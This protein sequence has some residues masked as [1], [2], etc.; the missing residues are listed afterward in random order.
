MK[1]LKTLAFLLTALAFSQQ[2]SAEAYLQNISTRSLVGDGDKQQ[3]AGFVLSGSGNKSLLIKA[4]GQGL[5]EYGVDTLLNP[6]L[7]LIAPGTTSPIY[8]N[9]NWGDDA[10]HSEIPQAAQPSHAQDS[11]MLYQLGPGAYTAQV[12]PV[13]GSNQIGLVSVDD[14][15]SNDTLRLI[16]ISTRSL[17]GTGENQAIL[18][19]VIGGNEPLTVL[20]KAAGKSLQSYGVQTELDP[21]MQL[22]NMAD[23]SS[24]GTND[25]WQNYAANVGIPA[26]LRPTHNQ[27]AAMLISLEPG[28]Y[29]VLVASISNIEDIGLVSI[30]VI[31]GEI[32]TA[33]PALRAAQLND[34]GIT[35]SSA[36]TDSC[37]GDNSQL[38]DCASGRDASHNDDSDGHAGFSF[39][40]ITQSAAFAQADCVKDNVTGLM[41]E[42][43]RGGNGIPG[44]EGLHDPDDRYFWYDS[45]P[46]TN[47]GKVGHQDGEYFQMTWMH[48]FTLFKPE[49]A[50]YQAGNPES[51]CN[52]EAYI[53]RVNARGLC[54]YHDWRLPNPGELYSLADYKNESLAELGNSQYLIDTEYFPDT[55][56][57]YY[58]TD[59][60]DA[61]IYA[62]TE[63]EERSVNTLRFM[64][65]SNDTD[66]FWV[67]SSFKTLCVRLVRSTN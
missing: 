30:D 5:M 67:D 23:G 22:I 29:T 27:D 4:V 31:N 2:A 15:A 24:L 45:S 38:E 34:T 14:L 59:T 12:T 58:W 43:K 56:P 1:P 3:I 20:V 11:A 26:A 8:M 10:R 50:G 6:G 18:G 9:D 63:H 44:D 17:V 48:S 28:A 53:A 35:H 55:C 33:C 51:Y 42:V 65:D 61:Y 40:K 36:N 64:L 16:N 21:Y 49:C 7:T 57:S 62:S 39:T 60:P 13:S 41:W 37:T 32:C 46:L 52:T 47:G 66:I 54:G 25:D 19:F